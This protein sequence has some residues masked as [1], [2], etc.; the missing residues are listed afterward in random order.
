MTVRS[1]RM[2]LPRLAL[3][4][5]LAAAT[6]AAAQLVV[7]GLPWGSP[8]PEVRSRLEGLGWRFRGAD[9]DGDEVFG[10]PAGSRA[11]AMLAEGRLVSLE[12]E[13]PGTLP[14]V[15]AR[16]DAATDSLRRLLGPPRAQ[17][18]TGSTWV[19]DGAT[20]STWH[21]DGADGRPR[22][23]AG[24]SGMGPGAM[25]ELLRRSNAERAAPAGA[26]LARTW[27]VVDAVLFRSDTSQSISLDAA[28]FAPAGPGRYRARM[29]QDWAFLR[30]LEN[31]MKYAAALLELEIDCRA[32]Q[33]RVLR[34]TPVFARRP[35]PVALPGDDSRRWNA[36]A[37][38]SPESRAIRRSCE[39]MRGGHP[40]LRD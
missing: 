27:V 26:R 34:A 39:L 8:Q 12:L 4:L 11:V 40:A 38:A 31:G 14:Y 35:L 37:A 32:T 17:D 1:L 2:R 21:S 24:L 13:W 36:P 23:T 22:P 33:A 28:G 9:Q 19:S 16:Y 30:R 20:L 18:E 6:P 3:P 10:G 5:L 29:R 25:H 15:R 7:E